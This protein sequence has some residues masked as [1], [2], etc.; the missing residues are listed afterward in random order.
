MNNSLP[1]VAF[2]HFVKKVSDI[3]ISYQFYPKLGLRPFGIKPYAFASGEI[4]IL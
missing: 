4:N 3:D 2:G 1:T